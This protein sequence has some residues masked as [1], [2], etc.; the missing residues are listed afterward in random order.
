MTIIKI[1]AIIAMLAAFALV[2]GCATLIKA[3]N[4]Y[5]SEKIRDIDSQ[6]FRNPEN[7]ELF[8]KDF[9]PNDLTMCIDFRKCVDRNRE[10]AL[11]N[12]RIPTIN[13]SYWWDDK[14]SDP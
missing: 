10:S 3:E 14:W 5:G 13:T 2:S 9:G 4:C 7:C 1:L 8:L 11:M 6:Y 12:P